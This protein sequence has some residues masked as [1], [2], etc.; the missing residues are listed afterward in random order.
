[1]P[2]WHGPIISLH[3]PRLNAVPDGSWCHRSC[4]VALAVPRV[5]GCGLDAPVLGPKDNMASNPGGNSM[6]TMSTAAG[7][8][9]NE[10]KR[11]VLGLPSAMVMSI[12]FIS[13]TIGV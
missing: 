9:T 13:P 12:A 11:N 8:G 1:M 2:D 10:L 5:A 4:A 7:A 6:S 3:W